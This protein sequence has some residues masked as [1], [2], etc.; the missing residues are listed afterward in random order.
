M[1]VQVG[2]RADFT[3][4]PVVDIGELIATGRAGPDLAGRILEACRD[5]GFMYVVNHGISQDQQDKIFAVS[6]DFFALPMDDKMAVTITRSKLFRGYL[7][8]RAPTLGGK[9]RSGVLEGFQIHVELPPDH[10]N[11]LAGKPLYGPNPW[12]AAMPALRPAMLEYFATMRTFGATMLKGFAAA[13]GVDDEYFL[14][15]YQDPLMMLRLLHYPQQTEFTD[16]MNIGVRA[17][18]DAGGFTILLQDDLGGLEVKNKRD[19]W[20]RVPPLKGS[21][22]INLGEMMECWTNGMFMATPHRVI[23]TGGR[24]RYS[25]PF[26]M[27]PDY[28]AEIVPF[29]P[30]MGKG[31]FDRLHAGKHLYDTY[32]RIWPV[33]E[34]E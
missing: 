26:F 22:V 18:T 29:G 21:Y 6:R 8:L 12:P 30:P 7:P 31:R 10:P 34:G 28:D 27:N 14:R 1:N 15:C 9:E 13:L 19:E 24:G 33:Y 2:R 5:V 3:E 17:H 16:E 20:I 32:Q 11:V 25:V 4:I 23:N